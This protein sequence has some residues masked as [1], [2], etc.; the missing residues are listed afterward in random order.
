M[1]SKTSAPRLRPPHL[2]WRAF[3]GSLFSRLDADDVV[4]L[5]AEISFY[6]SLALFP[7]LLVLGAVVGILPFTHSWQAILAWITHYLPTDV[8]HTVFDTVAGLTQNRK[9]FLSLGLLGSVWAASGGITTLMSALNRV[10][11]VTETR[12]YLKRVI[13]SILLLF[14]L[15]LLLI[16]TF[17]LLSFGHWFIDRIVLTG[18]TENLAIAI[19]ARIMR[20]SLSI[21]ISILCISF[22]HYV[23]PN[24]KRPWRWITH[25]TAMAVITWILTSLAFNYYILRI[26]SYQ[27]TYGILAG[28]FAL[29]VWVYIM[30]LIG[31]VGAEI[32]SEL[33]KVPQ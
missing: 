22:L 31:L 33:R 10:Y 5:S 13:W 14:V 4:G 28:F 8:Q 19:A 12:S 30:S 20:W 17:G 18:A 6:F 3:L 32:D 15:A 25:G 27:K 23:L 26:A 24:T 9:K 2:L 7:F 16:S 29:M 11:G 1:K 21:V